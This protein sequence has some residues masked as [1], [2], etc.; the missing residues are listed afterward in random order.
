MKRLVYGFQSFP[1]KLLR[2]LCVITVEHHLI[3]CYN[4]TFYVI[5][6]ELHNF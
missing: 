2:S 4:A 1:A 3:D 5:G 6:V